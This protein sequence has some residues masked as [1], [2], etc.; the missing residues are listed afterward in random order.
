MNSIEHFEDVIAKFTKAVETNDGLSLAALFT[1]D[2]VYDD[3]FYGEF[4][5]REAIAKML[6][7]HFW[8]HAKGFRWNMSNLVSD[9]VH[10]YATYD[11]S[12]T[13]IMPE[14]RGKQVVFDG[15]AHYQFENGLI[16][17]YEE[18]FNTGMALA[19]LDFDPVRIKKHLQ[20][21]AIMLKMD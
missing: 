6:N 14:A 11:F 9:G 7:D 13:S 16:K 5:G 1:E 10:G 18:N 4:K 3:E 19:Q 15:I 21:K 20:K 8:G 12:Y 2:G 17:R